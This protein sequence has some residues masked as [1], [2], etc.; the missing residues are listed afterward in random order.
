MYLS[1]QL[2]HFYL[3]SCV[4]VTEAM[5]TI[6][7]FDCSIAKVA[8]WELRQKWTTLFHQLCFIQNSKIK[9]QC[10]Y[11]L[12]C[13]PIQNYGTNT[14]LDPQSYL[15]TFYHDYFLLFAIIFCNSIG[16]ATKMPFIWSDSIT[17]TCKWT[18]KKI[19]IRL[20]TEETEIIL[21]YFEYICAL[22]VVLFR[23][24]WAL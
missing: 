22:K 24:Q 8:A 15:M 11:C 9:K 2:K 13:T 7:S 4:C 10:S 23:R 19:G 5:W 17:G 6:T 16:D 20:T 1:Q 14:Y 3:D 18:F 12:Q 21:Y